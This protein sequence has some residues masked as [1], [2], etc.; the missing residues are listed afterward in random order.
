[1]Y[2]VGFGCMIRFFCRLLDL[3]YFSA[4]SQS[5]SC[6]HSTVPPLL[7][8][9]FLFFDTVIYHDIPSFSV[10]RFSCAFQTPRAT[11]SFAGRLPPVPP[12]RVSPML[13]ALQRLLDFDGCT[14]LQFSRADGLGRVGV[15][16]FLTGLVFGVHI[17]IAGCCLAING[18]V[19][20]RLVSPQQRAVRRGIGGLPVRSRVKVGLCIEVTL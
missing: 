15:A 4:V 5:S 17:S 10:Q 13:G 19:L 2:L 6:D 8:S 18:L 14:N 16:G 11:F 1:M 20:S 7:S 3:R 9:L 12:S